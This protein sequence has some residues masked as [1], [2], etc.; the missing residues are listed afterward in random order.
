MLMLWNKI[1]DAHFVNNM[2]ISQESHNEP[3]TRPYTICDE[4]ASAFYSEEGK[5]L[6]HYLSDVFKI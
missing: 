5:R 6:M 3:I 1:E 2:W 4:V